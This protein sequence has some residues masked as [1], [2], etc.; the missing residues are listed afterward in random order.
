MAISHRNPTRSILMTALLGLSLGACSFSY[1]SGSS[2]SNAPGRSSGKPV[3]RAHAHTSSG[4]VDNRGKPISRSGSTGSG[5]S[6]SKGDSEPDAPSRVDSDDDAP[7]RTPTADP[8]RRT[9]VAPKRTKVPATR[10]P[11]VDD[12]TTD[13]D[14]DDDDDDTTTDDDGTPS[15]V[16]RS[17]ASNTTI[18]AKTKTDDPAKRLVA[19]Q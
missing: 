15:T 10:E 7:T 11:T 8:P 5:K 6:V 16:R 19:P 3:S 18:R 12:D 9:K 17:P 13:T 4:K 2:P 1:S 14:T